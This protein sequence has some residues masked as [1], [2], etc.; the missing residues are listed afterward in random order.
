MCASTDE[1]LRREF[2]KSLTQ[3]G[4]KVLDPA[5]GTG[6]FIVNLIR[7]YIKP[8]R[9]HEKYTHD[10]FCNEAMLLP[11]YIASLNIEHEY[12]EQLEEYTPFNGICFVDTLSLEGLQREI[13]G[14]N[15]ENTR[16][17]Q[18]E[19]DAQIM[20]ILGNPPYN[21]GQKNENQNSKNKAYVEESNGKK[22]KKGVDLR[23]EQTYV[24]DSNAQ[25][26]NKSYDV[27]AKFFRWA[28]DRLQGQD[29]L[30]C[31]ISNNSFI[32]KIAL[33]GMR[34]H[35]AWDFT[36]IYHL[37]LGGD[38]RESSSG[39]VFNIRV[40][41]GITMLVRHR[42]GMEK[43]YPPATIHYYKV[44]GNL[45]RS[46]K[47]TFL[48]DKKSI[49]NIEWQ[50]LTPDSQANWITQGL[51]PEFRQFLPM[52]DQSGKSTRAEDS[53]T[54]FKKY[55]LGVSTNR[56]GVVYSFNKRVLEK[57]IGQFIE[58]YNVE[59]SKWVRGGRPKDIDNAVS[60]EK[61]KWSEHLKHELQREQYGEFHA[62]HFQQA[63]YRPFC[64]RWLYYDSLLVDRPGS[65][66][67][68]YPQPEFQQENSMICIAGI[69]H[70]RGFGC[71]A[72]NLITSLDFAFE[73]VQ[74]FPYYTYSKDGSNRR[75]NI[76]D[77]ALKRFQA[78]YDDTVTKRDIF[79]YVYALLHHPHYRNRYAEDLKRDLPRIPLIEQREAF[80]TCV[81]LGKQLMDLHLHYE[82]AEEYELQWQA[83]KPFSWRV[84]KKMK[85]TKDR[86]A[87]SVNDS[88]TLTG[89][90]EACFQYKLG[91]RSALEWIIDQYQVK[92]GT[93]DGPAS[94]PNRLDDK[95]Y[96]VHLVG[97][98]I[99]VSIET[100]KLITEL[101]RI[102][103]IED[104]TLR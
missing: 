70:R 71:F 63:M 24:K 97:K 79:H 59:V 25:L 27:Y 88:L 38:A 95:E 68:F 55:S 11:Y 20:V 92:Q 2:G 100:T 4:V 85:L 32:H 69:G 64:T 84:E 49:H 76:T 66:D 1:V 9:L 18:E 28:T 103:I 21:A 87:L 62:D 41:V 54:L 89:I 19:K 93:Q 6:N 78:F 99:T 17:I 91:S 36:D 81:R 10:L 29:G 35:L 47:L 73:K 7:H 72:T 46:D 82:K 86:S 34:K 57:R 75:E 104:A 43:P 22:R 39:N 26:N 52:G 74:C 98:V 45:T 33:D 14:L 94:D 13:L 37:D 5:T 60:Y 40:G 56:D 8:Y 12:Y 80:K 16:R 77:W 3:P 101:E 51:H 61:V 53:A 90:P 23:I 42:N 65:F 44:P 30:V 15:E 83:K 48:T 67:E 58:D 50:E 102:V 96:I 31:F